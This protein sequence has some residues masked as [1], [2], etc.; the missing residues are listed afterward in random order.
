MGPTNKV[1]F[2]IFVLFTSVFTLL[3]YLQTR[4][5][6]RWEFSLVQFSSFLMNWA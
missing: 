5:D 6:R 4:I 3:Y 2:Y 1:V